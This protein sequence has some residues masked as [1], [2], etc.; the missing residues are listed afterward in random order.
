MAYASQNVSPQVTT[1]GGNF[2]IATEHATATVG[3]IAEDYNGRRFRYCKAAATAMHAGILVQGASY[4]T[5]EVDLAISTL[6][7]GD[8]SVTMTTGSIYTA[9]EYAGE[10]FFINDGESADNTQGQGEQHII[11]SH[12]AAASG[13]T[14]L[15]LQLETPI[16][17][18]GH[19]DC[20]G[21]IIKLNPY[22]ACVL[23]TAD[24]PDAPVIGVCI[25]A[26]PA[27]YYFWCQTRGICVCLG[28]GTMCDAVG[29]GLE[30]GSTAGGVKL[31]DVSA[32][33]NLAPIGVAIQTVG[34]DTEYRPIYIDTGH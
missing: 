25:C 28:G 22:K 30:V 21:G 17:E 18:V 14:D 1:V 33:T 23:S 15:V 5:T 6:A 7:V 4:E 9:N 34:V 8:T 20:T 3:A 27:S 2:N 32:E 29:D 12:P 26:V 24:N 19:A 10:V 13:A 31:H 16:I 11:R